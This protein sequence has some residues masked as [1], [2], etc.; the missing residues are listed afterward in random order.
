MDMDFL[1]RVSGLGILAI[2]H[3]GNFFGG[4]YKGAMDYVGN[5]LDFPF[6]PASIGAGALGTGLAFPIISECCFY[7]EPSRLVD[8]SKGAAIGSVLGPLEFSVGYLVG[9][10]GRIVFY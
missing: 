6:L 3:G 8:M 4:I 10:I 2:A 7:N 5:D 9:K 1:G